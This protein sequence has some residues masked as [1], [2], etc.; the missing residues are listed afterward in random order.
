MRNIKIFETY[1]AEKKGIHPAIYSHLEKFFKKNAKGTFA[2]A[3]EYLK[4]KMKDWNL[5][6]DDYTEAKKRFC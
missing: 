5:S 6:K 1:I 4:P 3:K 2:E